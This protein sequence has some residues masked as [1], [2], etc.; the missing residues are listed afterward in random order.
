M[1][2]ILEK[3]D[4]IDQN[5]DKLANA[6]ILIPI[7]NLFILI[8]NPLSIA[9]PELNIYLP[10]SFS[11]LFFILIFLLWIFHNPLKKYCCCGGIIKILYNYIP[12]GF[13]GSLLFLESY[14]LIGVFITLAWFILEI[15]LFFYLK[16][17]I[18]DQSKKPI[19]YRYSISITALFFLLSYVIA[20]IHIIF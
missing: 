5:D 18:H 1:K 10:E 14:F 16:K 2:S 17:N 9:I 11:S 15:L 19:F 8:V 3:I 20:F 4:Q 6:S 7:F 13:V 12:I